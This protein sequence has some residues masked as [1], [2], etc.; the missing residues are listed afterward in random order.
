MWWSDRDSYLPCCS[1]DAPCLVRDGVH[2]G[3]DA[4]RPLQEPGTGGCEFDPAGRPGEKLYAEFRLQLFDLLRQRRLGDVQTF[5]GAP[6]VALLG[7]GDE[8]PDVP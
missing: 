5:R 4:A 2:R 3:E 1:R 7:D 8:V 6:E